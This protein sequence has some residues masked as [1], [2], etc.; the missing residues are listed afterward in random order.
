MPS[1]PLALL[2]PVSAEHGSE[3]ACQVALG[4]RFG[5]LDSALRPRDGGNTVGLAVVMGQNA[6]VG[7][8]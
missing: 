6:Y 4:R 8:P 3:C 7:R 5:S 1:E 2:C